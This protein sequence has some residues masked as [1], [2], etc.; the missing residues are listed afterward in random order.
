MARILVLYASHF[1]QTRAIAERI[2]ARASAHHHLVE[3]ADIRYGPPPPEGYD[4]VA[5]GSRVELGRHSSDIRDYIVTH[6][7]ALEAI[8]TAFFSVCMAAAKP[9]ATADPDGYMASMFDGTGWRPSI[10]AS[11]AGALHYRKYNWLIRFIMKR[12]SRSAGHTT[13][14]SRDHV[15]TDWVRVEAF[16]D[17]LAG[18]AQARSAVARA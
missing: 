17:D 11:F 6:R 16:A 1:G 10:Q 5:I 13:D 8:P 4:V 15:F 18:L 9:G 3:L 14:T 7:H 12:I 2:A